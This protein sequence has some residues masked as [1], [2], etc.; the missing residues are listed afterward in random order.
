MIRST[1]I[2]FVLA[3]VFAFSATSAEAQ[4]K[5]GK[6]D[7]TATTPVVKDPKITINGKNGAP[8][9]AKKV[10]ASNEPLEKWTRIGIKKYKFSFA[11][12]EDWVVNQLEHPD[13]DELVPDSTVDLNVN[14]FNALEVN[15]EAFETGAPYILVYAVKKPQQSFDEFF[16]RLQNDIGFTG[17]SIVGADSTGTF[18]GHPMYD[19]TYEVK[20]LQANVRT[21]VIYANGYRY[22][23]MYTAIEDNRGSAFRKH[24]PRFERL[25]ETLQVGDDEAANK[26]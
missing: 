7:N 22:G 4:Q 3:L 15:R 16:T 25:L 24:M 11:Y 12:P 20:T 13:P 10:K 1:P 5:K 6:P 17:A 23:L 9:P 18:K 14:D 8:A 19:V 2:A 21:M 26:N